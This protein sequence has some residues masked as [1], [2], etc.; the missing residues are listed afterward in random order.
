MLSLQAGDEYQ[1]NPE[2]TDYDHFVDAAKKVAD[3]ARETVITVCPRL[4]H[5]IWAVGH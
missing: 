2:F 5:T 4:Y 3:L 1:S